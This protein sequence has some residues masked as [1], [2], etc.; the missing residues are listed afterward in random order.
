MAALDL[1]QNMMIFF[2]A[3]LREDVERMAMEE[4]LIQFDKYE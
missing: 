4:V 2:L 3:N 1:F